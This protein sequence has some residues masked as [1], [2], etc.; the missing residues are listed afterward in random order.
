MPRRGEAKSLLE[1]EASLRAIADVALASNPD[2][3]SFQATD[4]TILY[5]NPTLERL[6]GIPAGS[7][8]GKKCYQVFHG[9]DAPIPICPA[10]MLAHGE[11]EWEE[12]FFEPR[13]GKWIWVRTAK[14]EL[15]NGTRG[16]V[17]TVRDVTRLK[18]AEEK[19]ENDARRLS[20]LLKLTE[21]LS[22]DGSLREKLQRV[23]RIAI[24]ELN[25]QAGKIYLYRPD[26]EVLERVVIL[27]G[28]ESDPLFLALGE[29]VSGAAALSDDVIVIDDVTNE[30]ALRR[31]P[32]L[33]G[34]RP[35]SV[36][37]APL[38]K[39][40]RLLG[41]IN[42]AGEPPRRFSRQEIALFREFAT[43]LANVIEHHI[44]YDEL[45]RSV[46]EL[47]KNRRFLQKV[48]DAAPVG[49]M[50]ADRAGR[51]VS[52]NRE[53]E[54]LT[55]WRKDQ[56]LGRVCPF[57]ETEMCAW[58]PPLCQ[59][60][61]KPEL[62]R[63]IQRFVRDDGSIRFFNRTYTRL[64]DQDGEA[65]GT[66]GCFDDVT[67]TIRVQRQHALL[68]K[69]ARQ[70]LLGKTFSDLA[71]SVVRPIRHHL[72]AKV[73]CLYSWDG[74]SGSPFLEAQS[75]LPSQVA[76]RLRR[77]SES[78]SGWSRL[79]MRLEGGRPFVCTGRPEIWQELF[80]DEKLLVVPIG[81]K[82]VLLGFMLA[83]APPPYALGEAGLTFLMAVSKEIEATVRQGDLV[84]D[85]ENRTRRLRFLYELGQA[86]LST[87]DLDVMLRAVASKLEEY[88]PEFFCSI[89][90]LDRDGQTMTVRAS[91]GPEGDKYVG[92]KSKADEGITGLAW[93]SGKI[94]YVP[95]V[96]QHPRYMCWN[97]STRS[98]L[99]LPL[100]GRKGVIGLLNLESSVEDGF[101]DEDIRTFS[102]VAAQ[103]TAAV[104]N[105]ILFEE[106]LHNAWELAIQTEK[107]KQA[108]ELK[109]QF[110]SNVSH[111]LRTPLNAILGYTTHVLERSHNLGEEDRQSLERVVVSGKRLLR[112]IND[113]LDLSKI[114]AG[115]MD[116]QPEKVDL[117]R[118]ALA[119]LTS[120]E[121]Q[122]REKGLELSLDVP[123]DIGTVETDPLRLNQILVNLLGNAVKFTDSGYVRLKIWGD[124][125][126]VTLAV[127]D[128][129]KGIPESELEAIFDSFRQVDGSTT[130]R[131]GGTGLGLA[132][133]RKLAQL[134][135]GELTVESEVGKGSTFFLRL[136]RKFTPVLPA[137]V[138]VAEGRGN[139]I[140][141]NAV[142]ETLESRDERDR[143][144][145]Q[146]NSD[147]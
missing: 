16:F 40:G 97:P 139:P 118:A 55:G 109:S 36:L 12:T 62:G 42:L 20:T 141:G 11:D 88:L 48:V 121:P 117:R 21:S 19:A 102:T 93:S 98:E 131:A 65:I 10:K 14:A 112:L 133:S 140:L 75:G 7:L 89:H 71:R 18:K 78:A 135:G 58:H 26:R 86:S 72:E 41:V 136:P 69:I 100:I 92:T 70:R 134:L 15:P 47:E 28:G 5:A 116:V 81:Q 68:L 128:T 73:F 6:L 82:D 2:G 77:V 66:V 57:L 32:N 106:V 27:K 115:K 37:A 122:A 119:A 79:L 99:V 60:K 34:K 137:P 8:V 25:L 76:R 22:S 44:L 49:I 110:L 104:E 108:S 96:R 143:A 107:A 1:D 125:N 84:H 45:Q 3:V 46:A 95:D 80:P 85:L 146:A 83:V 113:L 52:W 33:R 74:Y 9:T 56:V 43:R 59:R 54:R 53:A 147:R 67:E 29:K 138:E 129:G 31:F 111:E 23:L 105:V 145:R 120:V 50:I 38:R 144:Q 127:E 101:A 39:D 126:E 61:R 103:M 63:K 30:S 51:I 4:Y 17:H 123:A 24:Q 13:L 142:H 87:L 132:V 124:E 130:R 90:I 35:H 94:V 64:M 91:Y 114:E